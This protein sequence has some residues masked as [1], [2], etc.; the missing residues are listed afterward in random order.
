MG[1]TYKMG[2]TAI[3]VDFPFLY[4]RTSK[5]FI[6]LFLKNQSFQ[7]IKLRYIKRGIATCE[8]GNL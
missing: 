8:Y 2:T 3:P 6:I 4:K 5:P 1:E 7:P